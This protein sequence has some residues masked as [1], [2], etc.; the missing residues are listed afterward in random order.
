M[1]L[2]PNGVGHCPLGEHH[3]NGRDEHA[4]FQVFRPRRPGGFCWK[5]YAWD[6]GGNAFEF[7]MHYHHLDAQSLWQQIRDGRL[8]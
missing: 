3:T 8:P 2:A 5:C 6:R 1:Q 7:L 4:S